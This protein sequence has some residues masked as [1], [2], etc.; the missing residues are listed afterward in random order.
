[1]TGP[2]FL[3]LTSGRIHRK[4]NIKKIY[5]DY[6]KI[7][8]FHSGPKTNFVVIGALRSGRVTGKEK[9]RRMLAQTFSSELGT[10]GPCAEIRTPQI[11]GRNVSTYSQ[12]LRAGPLVAGGAVHWLCLTN[13]AGYVL[14]LR[15]RAAPPPRLAVTKLPERVP[16]NG[17][18]QIQYL[19][20]TME[21]GGSP[22]VVVADKDKISAWTQSKHSAR[23]NQQPQVVIECKAMS[24]LLA[25]VVDEERHR[26]LM[27]HWQFVQRATNL[28][29]FAERSGIVLI[30]INVY[31]DCFF[32][33]DLQSKQI[34]NC[35]TDPNISYK[36]VYCPYE[37][38][39]S[40]WVPSFSASL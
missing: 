22:A 8:G 12:A 3:F 14:K 21:A 34:V 13:T 6:N 31:D 7:F 18:W 1:M 26:R 30:K 33:L 11:Q 10:W 20:V 5:D 19:L 9:H 36:D 40:N 4:I 17:G 24:R 23:W 35:F 15:V 37:M 2:S 28:V 39:L 38:G 27:Y 29:G 25:N 16:Y 32:W